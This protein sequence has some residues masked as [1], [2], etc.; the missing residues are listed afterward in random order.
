MDFCCASMAAAAASLAALSFARSGCSVRAISWAVAA[1]LLA[2]AAAS[3]AA[4]SES[5]SASGLGS[6]GLKNTGNG[7]PP[8]GVPLIS[9]VS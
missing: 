1:R 4:A 5:A 7:D 8:V 9:T 6:G 2:G 3:A